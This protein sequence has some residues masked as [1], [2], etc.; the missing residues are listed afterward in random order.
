MQNTRSH[1]HLDLASAVRKVLLVGLFLSGAC[2]RLDAATQTLF[3]YYV[4]PD[5]TVYI[6]FDEVHFHLRAT[7]G[8]DAVPGDYFYNIDSPNWTIRGDIDVRVNADHTF[9]YVAGDGWYDPYPAGY[10]SETATVVCWGAPSGSVHSEAAAFLNITVQSACIYYYGNNY[11]VSLPV[12]IGTPPA[13]NSNIKPNDKKLCSEP[14]SGPPDQEQM[15]RYSAHLMLASLNIEDSPIRYSPPRGPAVNFTVTYNQSEVQ[16]PQTFSYSNLGPQ[17]T[18]NWLSY[19]VDDPNNASADA[20]V[21]VPGGGTEA[22]L[23]FD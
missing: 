21:F 5:C 22:Y 23:G 6:G 10:G 12:T 3:N 19:V 4:P 8:S 7:V 20:T 1:L 16:Q 11:E 13:L 17:W 15:A 2:F 14:G 9:G 18:F